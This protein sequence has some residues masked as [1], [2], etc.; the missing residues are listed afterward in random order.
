MAVYQVNRATVAL[1]TAN[2]SL[3]LV[4]VSGR[5]LRIKRI[6]LGGQGTS[7][8]ANVMM[9]MRSTGGTTGGGAITPAPTTSGA[10]AAAFAAYT[11]WSAQPTPG[12][13]L[14]RL[15]VNTN[16]GLVVIY[17]PPG[18]ELELRGTEQLSFRSETGT[19]FV[20]LSVVVEE[21]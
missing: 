13:V 15:P 20:S 4:G 11:T 2:D 3:T 12:A 5:T 8:A 14:D 9:V 18:Q 19:G 21:L 16:G 6:T 7:S 17:Y 1:S 10:A